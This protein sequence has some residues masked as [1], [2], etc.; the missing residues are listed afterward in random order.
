MND[1]KPIESVPYEKW[2]LMWF[3]SSKPENIYAHACVI[4]QRIYNLPGERG[5]I[6]YGGKAHPVDIVT[7]WQELPAG[8]RND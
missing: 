6:W 2:V 5:M 4:A 3:V 8:P 1:W 7:H